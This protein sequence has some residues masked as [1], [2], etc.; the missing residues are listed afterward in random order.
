MHIYIYIE[1]CLCIYM[2]TYIC[3]YIYIY[4]YIPLHIHVVHRERERYICTPVSALRQ[5]RRESSGRLP[6]GMFLVLRVRIQF[7]PS[8]TMTTISVDLFSMLN[9]NVCYHLFPFLTICLH[10]SLFVLIF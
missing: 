7:W 4:I 6:G 1:R 10:G 5:P 3:V 8:S 9:S 2:H